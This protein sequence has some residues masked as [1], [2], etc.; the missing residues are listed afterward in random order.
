MSMNSII[1]GA[2][3]P[4]VPTCVPDLYGGK[5]TTYCTFQYTE[6]PRNFGDDAPQET[7]YLVQV[8]LFAARGENTLKT[9]KLLRQALLAAGFTAP[10]IENA[11]DET[12]QHY[13]FECEYA[14]GWDDG[15]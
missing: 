15:D 13:V 8:H 14:G 6:F 12:S 10:E 4:V 2:V 9:R 11:S 5:E 1:R 3:A 7:L